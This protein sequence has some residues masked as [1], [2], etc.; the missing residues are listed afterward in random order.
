MTIDN[1][2]FYWKRAGLKHITWKCKKD[3]CKSICHV[4]LDDTVKNCSDH[5]CTAYSDLEIR[6]L[7]FV[8]KDQKVR[9]Q[10]I[11]RYTSRKD[12]K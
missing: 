1:F 5:T 6:N 11:Q 2:V 3:T 12:V 10:N 7:N 8:K 4:N 9:I